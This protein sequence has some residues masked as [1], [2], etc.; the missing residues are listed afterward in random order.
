MWGFQSHASA[1]VDDVSIPVSCLVVSKDSVGEFVVVDVGVMCEA[2]RRVGQGSRLQ[3]L[4][5]L[6]RHHESRAETVILGL[7]SGVLQ[8]VRPSY[9]FL[10]GVGPQTAAW[11][12]TSRTTYLCAKTD[13]WVAMS[14]MSKARQA[15]IDAVVGA[16]QKQ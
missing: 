8:W 12:L 7:S 3:W 2:I 1:S 13:E 9:D 6:A 10:F 16:S 11:C 14:A 5:A 4:Q 15:W